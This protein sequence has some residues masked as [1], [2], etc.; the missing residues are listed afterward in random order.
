M[1]QHKA[2]ATKNAMT[3]ALSPTS[4]PKNGTVKSK[5][6]GETQSHNINAKNIVVS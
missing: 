1:P 2:S 5:I 3:T 4:H 6:K